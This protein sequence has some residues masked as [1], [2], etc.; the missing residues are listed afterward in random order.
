[1]EFLQVVEDGVNE[2]LVKDNWGEQLTDASS[3][4]VCVLKA[5]SNDVSVLD[6]MDQSYSYTYPAWISTDRIAVVG[7][8][9]QPFKLGLL[10]CNM[11]ESQVFITSLSTQE[12]ALVSSDYRDVCFSALFVS[13]NGDTLIA[14]MN[15]AFGPHM[16]FKSLL[17][18]DVA[19]CQSEVLATY[20]VESV[21]QYPWIDDSHFCFNVFDKSTVRAM[22]IDVRSKHAAAEY[23]LPSESTQSSHKLLDVLN[24]RFLLSK[25]SFISTPEI[26]VFK[27][28]TLEIFQ[29][30]GERAFVVDN[31][32]K[33][34]EHDA[35]GYYMVGPKDQ[36]RAR[37]CLLFVHGGPHVL[38]VDAFD[39]TIAFF[40]LMGFN[41]VMVNYRGSLGFTRESLNALPGNVGSMDVE[42]CH[43]ALQEALK[44]SEWNCDANKVAV[45]GGSH[46]GFLSLHLIGQYPHIFK[47]CSVR[48]PVT[49]VG[50][51]LGVTDIPDWCVCEVMN[52]K[53][54]YDAI[55][56]AD[57][58]AEAWKRSPLSNIE[59]V[60]APTQFHIGLKDKRVPPSQGKEYYRSLIGIGRVQTSLFEY[61]DDCHPLKTPKAEANVLI[62]THKWFVKHLSCEELL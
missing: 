58:Y 55:A 4:T 2:F 39:S 6:H 25:F 45:M 44:C 53:F 28:D 36:S 8:K 35:W 31:W 49:N 40:T 17:R 5:D 38:T 1:M 50:A 22:I 54:K 51:M 11:R 34:V 23:L 14:L 30:S 62:E 48:N 42:D 3:T 60:S 47:A 21:P 52:Q 15:D 27:R 12:T 32:V 61:P 33:K 37:P 16:Q 24:G 19:S 9:K 13:P 43:T 59:Q 29:S 7:Y 18:I 10:Y 20:S 26:F 57:F 56:D 41:M 46:G